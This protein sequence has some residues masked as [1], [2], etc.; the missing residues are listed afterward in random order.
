MRK[1]TRAAVLLTAALVS[2]VAG[3][4][5][6]ATYT[7]DW[8]NMAPTPFGSS[9][10]NNSVFTLPGVGLVTVTYSIPATFSDGRLQ[11][12]C[13]QNGNVTNGNTWNWTSHELFATTLLSGPDPLVPVT[14]TITYT[15]APQ[16][17]GS[18]YV[19]IGGLGAT[20]SFG[21]GTSTL[22]CNHNGFYINDWS[23]GC[24]HWGPTQY[25]CGAGTFSMQNSVTGA[26]GADPWWNTPLGVVRILDPVSS[27]TLIFNQLRGDGVG[28]NIGHADT[29]ITP[30]AP[31]TWG[32]LKSLYR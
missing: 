17:A 18:M 11:N 25:T 7:I 15:F 20:T 9:V 28:G 22:T 14:W 4:A 26:G 24:G 2:V 1:A 13:L 23:G 30:T 31:S 10:P 32:R 27:I 6:A 8:L 5:R 3:S 21:G 19:G 12:A 29:Q 16:P